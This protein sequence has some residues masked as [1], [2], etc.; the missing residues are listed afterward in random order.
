MS[1]SVIPCPHCGANMWGSREQCIACEEKDEWKREL[2]IDRAREER[3]AWSSG[4]D[5]AL[6]GYL[7]NPAANTD[8]DAQNFVAIADDKLAEYRKRFGGAE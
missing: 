6:N 1:G 3:E 8:W 5:A 2:G 4:Y 7:S